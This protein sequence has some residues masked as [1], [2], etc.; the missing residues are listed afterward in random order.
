MRSC[1]SK[2]SPALAI[3]HSTAVLRYIKW[4]KDDARGRRQT[5]YGSPTDCV[6]LFV[7]LRSLW[8]IFVHNV[9]AIVSYDRKEPLDIRTAITHHGLAE[10][11][12]TFNEPDNPDANDILLSREQAQIPMIY[13]KRRQRKRGQQAGC[14][15]RIRRQSN[16]PPLPS[17]LLA[18]VQSLEKKI[19]DARLNYQRDIQNSNILC[20]TESW[21]NDDTIN[22]QLAGYRLYRQDRTTASGKKRGAGLSIFVNNS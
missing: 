14:L 4:V 12:F 1:C 17:I 21:L 7:Y 20:F 13:M 8:F 5:F 3:Q 9:A 10:N 15:L 19:D 22:I 16:K 18:N 11:F 2:I 6:F